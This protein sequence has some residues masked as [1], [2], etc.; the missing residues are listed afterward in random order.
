MTKVI[1]IANQKGGVG[2]TATVI[3]LGIG[4]VLQGKKVLAIDLD[5]QGNLTL[6]FGFDPDDLEWTI[7][8]LLTEMTA[9]KALPDDLAPYVI[10]NDEG[11]DFIAADMNLEETQTSMQCMVGGQGNYLLK[12]IV[13]R[14]KSEY[15]YILIDCP[16]SIAALTYNGLIAAESV[17][18]PSQAQA[19]SAKG[20]SQLYQHIQHVQGTLNPSLEIMGILIT[21]MTARSLNEKQCIK[22]IQMI[23]GADVPIFKHIIPRSVH[24]GTS[25]YH[26]VSMHL[27][28]PE[29]KVAQA[30]RG[31]VQEVL[32]ERI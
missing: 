8:E 29:G 4:L 22:D 5:P 27:H 18:I 24:T 20:S 21:M 19:F 6:G 28:D 17:I 25:N 16:P 32:D 12:Q 2:K 30:Y 26:G 14:L 7:T 23:F 3:N 13:D 31:C 11:I 15:D 9:K 10:T 1:A